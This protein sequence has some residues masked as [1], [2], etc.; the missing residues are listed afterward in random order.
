MLARQ[1]VE[2]PSGYR[3]DFFSGVQ[4]LCQ[5]FKSAT[6]LLTASGP[7]PT[8][9]DRDHIRAVQD[10]LNG[11]NDWYRSAGGAKWP[12]AL[13]VRLL[14]H[15]ELWAV[16]AVSYLDALCGL[17]EL[18]LQLGMAF[19]Y[20]FDA[21]DFVQHEDAARRLGAQRGLAVASIRIGDD[22]PLAV[23]ARLEDFALFLIG[24]GVS[25]SFIAPVDRLRAFR[26]LENPVISSTVL[27]VVPTGARASG[28]TPA[29]PSSP[30]PPV[31]CSGIFQLYV[32][33]LGGV[34]PC[35]GLLDVPAASLGSVYEPFADSVLAGRSTGL[36]LAALARRGPVLESAR[37]SRTGARHRL[38]ALKLPAQ[39]SRHR[40]ELTG[41]KRPV[42]S[43]G[44]APDA[45][46]IK[47]NF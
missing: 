1:A 5:W 15:R 7:S 43:S 21:G 9:S 47:A 2:L 24:R 6:V 40:S 42:A 41:V 4:P 11:Y 37:H 36:D 32:S 34:F 46:A 19:G 35:A 3:A 18:S 17:S 13:R 26:L 27:R 22:A 44:R 8:V 16:G 30:G 20:T 14:Y 12:P 29:S 38:R 25:V 45:L 28:D 31:P 23:S 10:W 33:R 39:C